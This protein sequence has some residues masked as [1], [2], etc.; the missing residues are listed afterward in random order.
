MQKCHKGTRAHFV[1]E[2]PLKTATANEVYPVMPDNHK[3]KPIRL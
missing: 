3:V 1:H 2:T